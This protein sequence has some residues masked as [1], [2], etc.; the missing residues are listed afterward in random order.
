MKRRIALIA[1][2]LVVLTAVAIIVLPQTLLKPKPIHIHAGFQ[3]YKDGKQQD[4]SDFKYMHEAPCSIDGKP[5]EGAPVDE[6]MEKAHLHD[7]VGDVVHVHRNGAKWKDLF[8][9]IKYPIQQDAVAY[10]NG[11]KVENF[12]EKDIVSYESVLLFEGKVGD[13]A[14]LT[15]KAVTKD[16]IVEIEGRSETCGS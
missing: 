9:N 13:V 7:Q 14:A 10:I 12:L 1:T 8:M 16:H 15:K 3:V 2:V 4:F 6:Q 11:Q 5:I